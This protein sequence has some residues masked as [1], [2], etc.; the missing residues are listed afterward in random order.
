MTDTRVPPCIREG[1]TK[2]GRRIRGLCKDHYSNVWR[3]GTNIDYP[4]TNRSIHDVL[5]DWEILRAEGI[6]R[7]AE[8]MGMKRDSLQRALIRARKRGLLDA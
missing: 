4:R 1:C 8:R 3:N 5:A 6:T 2:G 7:A